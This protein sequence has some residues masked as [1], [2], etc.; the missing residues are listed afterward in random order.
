MDPSSPI[1]SVIIPAYK[2]AEYICKAIDSVISQ[3]FISWEMIIINDGSPDETAEAVKPYTNDPRINYIEQTNQGQAATRNRGIRMARGHLIQLLDDDDELAPDS[4]AW[5]VDFLLNQPAY[6]CVLGDVLYTGPDGHADSDWQGCDG[7]IGLRDLFRQSAF[8]SPGQ[9]LF[10]KTELLAIGLFDTAIPGV[11][12]SDLML[13]LAH[14]GRIKAVRRPALLYRWHGTNASAIRHPMLPMADAV[15]R[16]SVE[17][18]PPGMQRL[19]AKL[20]SLRYLHRYGGIP[21]LR[22]LMDAKGEERQLRK[23]AAATYLRI[24]FRNLTQF[25]PFLPFWLW[26][27]TLLAARR[28]RYHFMPSLAS[29][30]RIAY[31]P[32]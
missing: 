5:K 7:D 31:T 19:A 21:T 11:D 12:D 9:A 2:H 32:I 1:V 22:F 4:L 10:R 8:A 6:A 28:I 23:A 29:R 25:P 20:D 15:L 30:F 26:D 24:F 18:V 14:H 16:R 13:R 3:S 17:F 27:L